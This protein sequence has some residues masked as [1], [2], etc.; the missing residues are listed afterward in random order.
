MKIASWNIRGGNDPLKQQEALD[1]LKSHRIDVFGLLE[2]RVKEKNALK[3]IRTIFKDYKLVNNYKEHSNG[4]IWLIWKPSSVT[5]T[6]LLYNSQFIHCE[7][8][9]HATGHRFHVTMIYAS[10][11][12]RE[13]DI[14]WSHLINI[15]N[16]V[17]EWLLLGDFNVVRTAEEHVSKTPAHLADILDFNS[18]LLQCE[19]DDVY[20]T[21]SELTWNNKQEDEGQVWSKLDRALA[22]SSWLTTF[23]ATSAKFLAPGISDHSPTLVTVF[24]DQKVHARFSFL[25]CWI[26][27]PDYH[28]TVQSAWMEPVNGSLQFKL[29]AKLKNVK[30]KLTLMLP[31]LYL[32]EP[33]SPMSTATSS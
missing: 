4:R 32:Q 16:T 20:G 21:G 13:R 29:F 9:H 2:T 28:T 33:A 8:L 25:N 10:N 24:E 26:E 23:P 12:A 7:A 1:F 27:H 31:D 15:R 5:V 14:L 3:I 11:N 17:K 6:P 18:C 30:T 19:V 22:N